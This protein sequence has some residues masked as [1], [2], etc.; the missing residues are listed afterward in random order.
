MSAAIYYDIYLIVLTIIT[1]LVMARYRV[2][3][4]KSLEYNS[5]SG[6][7]FAWIICAIV[8]LFVGFR[9]ISIEFGDTV[10]TEEYYSHIYG[11]AFF[12]TLNTDNL[13]F[14]NWFAWMASKHFDMTTVFLL[15][16]FVY[17][18]V[19][20]IA[21]RRLFPNE[22]LLAFVVYLVAFSTFSYGTNG[23]KAGMAASVFLLAITYHKKLWLS[24]L[25]ALFTFT[26][27]HSMALV[28]A[29]YVLTLFV[30]NTKYYIVGW[31]I[32]LLMAILH[33]TYFQFLFAGFTDE[34]GA[35]Y[36]LYKDN[37]RFRIDFV[38]YSFVPIAIGYYLVYKKKIPSKGFYNN[39]LNLYITTNAVW[40]LCMYAEFTNRISYLSWFLYPVVLLYP[41]IYFDWGHNQRRYLKCV[42]YLHLGFTLFMEF[43]YYG[44]LHG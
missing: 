43:I 30:K 4:W 42:V 22:V 18:G 9:P 19:M 36:L 2:H 17:F 7:G 28:I 39:L 24:L 14:D 40:M 13:F 23:V 15:F 6:Y 11:D 27:H 12:F 26:Q 29:A 3:S 34:Q 5:N 37:T 41:F 35:S 20:L 10:S 32:C 8:V 44:F 21:L 16:A 25:I 1:M 31:L 33:I 38:L